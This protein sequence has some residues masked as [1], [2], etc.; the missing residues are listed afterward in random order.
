MLQQKRVKEV[1]QKLTDLKGKAD[2]F[3]YF[4]TSVC[5]FDSGEINEVDFIERV[6]NRVYKVANSLDE[7]SSS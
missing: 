5:L 7:Y 4:L 2:C 1:E 6:S 3:D